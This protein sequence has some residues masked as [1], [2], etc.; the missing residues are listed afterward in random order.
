VK[1]RPACR[2]LFEFILVIGCGLAMFIV[3]LLGLSVF[4]LAL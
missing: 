2:Y 1:I 3:L 4:L